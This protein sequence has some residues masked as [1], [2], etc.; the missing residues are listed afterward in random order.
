MAD[1]DPVTTGTPYFTST[2]TLK[3]VVDLLGANGIPPSNVVAFFY[4]G[5]NIT[6]VYHVGGR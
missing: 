1:P 4:N 5:T 3:Q 2:G 6:V